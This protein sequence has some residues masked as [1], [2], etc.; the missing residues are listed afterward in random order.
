MMRATAA[1]ARMT[2]MYR[3][4]VV[5]RRRVLLVKVDAHALTLPWTNFP[6]LPVNATYVF[7]LRSCLHYMHAFFLP[8]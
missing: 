8:S 2:A 6:S 7:T 3:R 5:S 1:A 4:R